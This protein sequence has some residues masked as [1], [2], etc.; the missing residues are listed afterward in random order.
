MLP[1]FE[2]PLARGSSLQ[3][4]QDTHAA[5]LGLCCCLLANLGHRTYPLCAL[6]PAAEKLVNGIISPFLAGTT[7][8]LKRINGKYLIG[9]RTSHPKKNL[10]FLSHFVFLKKK[11]SPLLKMLAPSLSQPL[12]APFR[13]TQPFVCRRSLPAQPP[14]DAAL[15]LG[16]DALAHSRGKPGP[17]GPP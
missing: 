9:V 12:L 2:Q 5:G 15:A 7:K 13:P 10:H 14:F 6:N 8:Q 3:Q 1:L 17:V 11:K 4:P 16:G